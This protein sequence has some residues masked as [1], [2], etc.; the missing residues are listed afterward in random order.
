MGLIPRQSLF[1][2]R[3]N[4]KAIGAGGSFLG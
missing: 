1:P 3:V 4:L 2:Q